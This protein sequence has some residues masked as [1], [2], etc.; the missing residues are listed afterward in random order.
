MSVELLDCIESEDESVSLWNF[1]VEPL[2]QQ[3]RGETPSTT[4]GDAAEVK[5][6]EVDANAYHRAGI[7]AAGSL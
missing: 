7:K 2:H 3:R 1:H 6:E 5:S 4:D